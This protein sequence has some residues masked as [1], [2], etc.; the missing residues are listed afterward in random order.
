M[1][2]K[3]GACVP[4]FGRHTTPASGQIHLG[5]E[6]RAPSGVHAEHVEGSAK[7]RGLVRGCACGIKRWEWLFADSTLQTLDLVKPFRVVV[8]EHC[9]ICV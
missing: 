1:Q 4:I 7:P 6:L 9:P 8:E 5:T 3:N 2:I